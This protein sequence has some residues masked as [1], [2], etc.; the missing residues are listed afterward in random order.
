[1]QTMSIARVI[2]EV[3][4]AEGVKFIF[5]FP[6]GH[7]TSVVILTLFY[8]NSEVVIPAKAGIQL[9]NTGFR[10]KPGMTNKAKTFLN[11]YTSVVYQ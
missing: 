1:M 3:F 4:K 2:L 5:S 10:I 6:G 11:H 9:N 8:I 7:N